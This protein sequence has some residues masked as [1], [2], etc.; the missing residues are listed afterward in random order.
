MQHQQFPRI[1]QGGG[2]FQSITLHL[3]RYHSSC[4]HPSIVNIDDQRVIKSHFFKSRS[5]R[6][7]VSD[8]TTEYQKIYSVSAPLMFVGNV[9]HACSEQF[10]FCPGLDLTVCFWKPGLYS[11]IQNAKFIKTSRNSHN[12]IAS[13]CL[14]LTLPS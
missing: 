11:D 10:E 13:K 7:L 1:Y 9:C 12:L 14:F 5:N 3:S 2:P 8:R 4:R 6:A